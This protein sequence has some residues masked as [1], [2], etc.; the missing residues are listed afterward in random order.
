MLTKTDIEY[1]D[2]RWEFYPGCANTKETCPIHDDCWARGMA[3][4]FHRDFTPHLIPEKLLDPLHRHKPGRIGVNFGG[5]TFGEWVDPEN[6]LSLSN[7]HYSAV[8]TLK[9]VVKLVVKEC[10][11]HKFLFLTKR[12]DRLHFWEPFPDNC[13]V[14][15]SVWDS[16]SA[17]NAYCYLCELDANHKWVSFEPLMGGCNGSATHDYLGA[18]I[19]SIQW[20]VIGGL[21]HGKNPPGL[22]EWVREIVTACDKAGIPVFLKNNLHS[23]CNNTLNPHEKTNLGEWV[24]DDHVSEFHL[25]QELP[26]VKG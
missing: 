26:E 23:L 25:R 20:V 7:S 21:S 6:M 22:I 24:E 14:G 15:A 5:D 4:R 12:P 8:S 19:A 1:L 10:P 16:Y 2:Y 13:W 18:L 9:D 3:H 11:Q 17:W